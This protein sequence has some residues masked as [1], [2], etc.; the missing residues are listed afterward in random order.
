MFGLIVPHCMLVP[1]GGLLLAGSSVHERS[2]HQL[3]LAA[4]SAGG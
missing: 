3:G 1:H 2:S 4:K